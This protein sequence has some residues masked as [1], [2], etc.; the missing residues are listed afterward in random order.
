MPV[1]LS[2]SSSIQSAA[3][4]ERIQKEIADLRRAKVVPTEVLC[5]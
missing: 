4:K 5:G 3:F 1:W 2:P